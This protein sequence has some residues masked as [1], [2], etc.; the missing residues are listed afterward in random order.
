LQHLL[1]IYTREIVGS[2]VSTKYT[3]ELPI[4]D[5]VDAVI[6]NGKPLI[7]HTDQGNEYKSEDYTSQLENLGVKVVTQQRQAL[8]QMPTRKVY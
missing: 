3:K 8:G 7:Y 2:S 6:K 5:F 1:D 4:G